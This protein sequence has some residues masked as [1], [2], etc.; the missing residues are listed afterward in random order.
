[1]RTNVHLPPLLAGALA[2]SFSLLGVAGR[3]HA[4]LGGDI[5]SVL[6][7]QTHLAA[8][9][10]VEKLAQGERH[11]LTLP[12]GIVVRQ[13]ISAAGAVYAV[14]WRG[15]HTPDLREILGTYF[16]QLEN[17]DAYRP[18]GHHRLWMDGADFA[19]RSMGHR[20]SFSGRAWVPSKVPA[21]INLDSALE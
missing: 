15:P 18:L 12:S 4:T 2:F 17:R 20:G 3:A 19:I 9:R 16:P 14:T 11:E 1:M 8:T 10:Q 13:Y 6:A 7:N 21:G 5:A